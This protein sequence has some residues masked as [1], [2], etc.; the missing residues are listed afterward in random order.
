MS[1]G[2]PAAPRLRLR[3]SQERQ[4]RLSIVAMGDDIMIRD[5]HLHRHHFQETNWWIQSIDEIWIIAVFIFKAGTHSMALSQYPSIQAKLLL[6]I[7]I[8]YQSIWQY[9]LDSELPLDLLDVPISMY[10]VV[11]NCRGLG[12]KPG[13]GQSVTVPVLPSPKQY[14]SLAALFMDCP[15]P[16]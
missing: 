6:L 7:G 2:L 15:R 8:P 11:Q 13:N 10:D 9:G 16:S 14:T 3:A 12:P 1:S 5:C 4:P